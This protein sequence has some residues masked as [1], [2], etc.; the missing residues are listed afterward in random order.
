RGTVYLPKGRRGRIFQNLSLL[1]GW[2]PRHYLGCRRADGNDPEEI[3]RS[4]APDMDVSRLNLDSPMAPECSSEVQRY[5]TYDELSKI[6]GI[7]LSTLRRRVK[8][9]SIPCIQPGGPRT[10][11]VFPLDVLDRS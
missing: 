11:V 1:C 8:D 3:C 9:G 6:T 7:S 10:R 5:L 4:G 2:H